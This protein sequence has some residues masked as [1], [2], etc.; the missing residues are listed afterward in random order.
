LVAIRW[1]ASSAEQVGGSLYLGIVVS[2]VLVLMTIGIH[3]EFL[4][5]M[6]DITESFGVRP[7][8]RVLIMMIGAIAAHTLEVYLFAVA[9]RLLDVSYSP[10]LFGGQF[11]GT[12]SDYV[13][14]SASCYTSLGVGDIWPEGP[15][16]IIGTSEALTGLIMIAWTA[17]FTYLMMG[18]YWGRD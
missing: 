8:L 2:I 7:R 16:R 18:R 1:L 12:F 6:P 15:V 17:S 10:D 4:R 13:Y 5:R 3:Y 9:Y 14:F 11:H